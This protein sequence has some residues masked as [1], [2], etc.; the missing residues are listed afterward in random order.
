MV[1]MRASFKGCLPLSTA[2]RGRIDIQG[3][4]EAAESKARLSLVEVVRNT[5]IAL[6]HFESINERK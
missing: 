6:H 2:G 1:Y 5:L 3:E 4:F